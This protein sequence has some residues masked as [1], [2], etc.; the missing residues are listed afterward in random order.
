MLE[1][2]ACGVPV[3]AASTSTSPEILGDREA[4]F[5]PFDPG[6]IARVLERT[7]ADEALLARLRAR[8]RARVRHYTWDH[9]AERTLVGYERALAHPESDGR[10]TRPRRVRARIALFSPWPPDRS[11]IAG[12]NRRLLAELGREVDVDVI[13]GTR[14]ESYAPPREPGVRLLH[15]S[16]F[17][18]KSRLRGYDR[19]VYCMGNSH[20]HGYVLEALE[21]EPGVVVCHDVR[22]AGFYGWYAEQERPDDPAGRFGERI[23]TMYGNRL[24]R[25]F[26]LRLPTPAEQSSLGIFMTHDVQARAERLVV[27]S[28]YAA[29]ILRLER[30]GAGGPPVTVLPLAFP[31]RDVPP[32]APRSGPGRL[33]VSFG[34]VSA[35]KHPRVLIEAFARL[36]AERPELRLVFAGGGDEPELR[37]WRDLADE[38][39]IGDR[40]ALEGHT[41]DRRWAE[42]LASADLA[43]QLRMVSNGEASAAVTE[44]M[45]AGLPTVVT[46]H[47]WFAELPD[48][49]VVKVPRELTAPVLAAAMAEVLDAPERA[50]AMAAAARA[51]AEANDFAAVARRYLEVL[52][53]AEAT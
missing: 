4:L 46:D 42:L 48:E 53:L 50:R 27:H 22:L 15:G 1:A 6:D 23:T 7:L 8:S 29:D 2:M 16:E 25:T 33:V 10:G 45:A 12:Y 21:R 44:T 17:S 39:G 5:D 43:V 51:H 26:S 20:F 41:P 49:A 13:V 28:G 9:V 35:V 11:G 24:G 40:V 19:H 3:A 30:Q 38:L 14:M 37:H 18:W 31:A 52:D 36:A 47:G 34:L 32:P